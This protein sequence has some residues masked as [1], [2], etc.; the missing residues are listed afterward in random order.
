M[1]YQENPS[2]NR[3]TLYFNDL[4]VKNLV[5]L[6]SYHY[7]DSGKVLNPHIH[8]DTLEI[9]YL[10]KGF[11]TY[12]V[13][14]QEF[15]LKGG[16]VFIT[17]P[18]EKHGTGQSVEEKGTLYWLQIQMTLENEFFLSYQN[19]EA[20]TFLD[21][22]LQ[23]SKRHF[24]I[25]ADFKSLLDQLFVVGIETPSP[26]QRIKIYSLSTQILL[27]ILN[28]STAKQQNNKSPEITKAVSFIIKN[29]N[30][31][32]SLEDL[33]KHVHLSESH[34][35]TKFKAEMGTS[36]ADFVQRK[37]IEKSEVLLAEG[38][39][40]ITEIAYSLGYPS[41][42]H[43]SSVFKKYNGKTPSEFKKITKP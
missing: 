30:Q 9:C 31:V 37:K 20:K 12:T 22:I 42:Q 35:K 28:A 3:K 43:F 6:G 8:K 27:S 7:T 10:D 2:M 32:F 24:S 11:Q 26:L 29:L 40:N 41:S 13:D 15:H 1:A 19:Q 36:P 21:S 16:D 38:K 5:L 39:L 25:H 4:G 18:N 23:I 33:A 14:E 17:F 34:F